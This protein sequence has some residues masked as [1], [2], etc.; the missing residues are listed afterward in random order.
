MKIILTLLLTLTTSFSCVC[1]DKELANGLAEAGAVCAKKGNAEQAI[2]ILYRALVYDKNCGLAL[3]ELAKYYEKQ[4]DTITAAQLFQRAAC[5]LVDTEKRMLS[6]TKAKLLNPSYAKLNAAM[7]EYARSLESISIRS[8]S[9][10][11]TEAAVD[12]T[13]A[14]LLSEVLPKNKMPVFVIKT[15]P[16]VGMF[17]YKGPW[18]TS[19][20]EIKEDLTFMRIPVMIGGKWSF[21]GKTLKLVHS[22]K[23]VDVLVANSH[24]FSNARVTLVRKEK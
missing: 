16:P 1:D 5:H 17:I 13:N 10:S 15:E 24:G 6:E 12:R 22:D 21:E 7:D 18:W 14:I 23:T 19:D 4:G 2:E 3:Y 11:V 20:F 9:R 8:A